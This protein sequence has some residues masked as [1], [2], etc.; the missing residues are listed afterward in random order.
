MQL[1]TNKDTQNTIVSY[2]IRAFA[3]VYAKIYVYFN[4][5]TFIYIY[6]HQIIYFTLYFIKILFPYQFFIIISNHLSL[7]QQKIT[8]LNLNNF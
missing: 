3:S 6:S 7:L 4:I 2:Y 1:S 8:A 5:I